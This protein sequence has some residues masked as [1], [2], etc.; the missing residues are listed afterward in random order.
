M[1]AAL[2]RYAGQRALVALCLGLAAALLPAPGPASAASVSV[3]WS[4][5][6]GGLS[7]PVQVV[8][9]KDGT[10]R[11]FIVEKAGRIRIWRD[12]SLR[13][14]PYLDIRDLVSDAG[15]RGLLSI[16][17][18][19]RWESAPYFWVSY[20]NSAGTLRVVRYRAS[21]YAANTAPRSSARPVLDVPHPAQYTNHNGG[22]LAFGNDG[23]LLI[24]TGDGGG[25][26]D[27]GNRAQSARS[28]S[29][30][31]L[32]VDVLNS[33]GS[34]RYCI[35]TTNPYAKSTVYKREIWA[36]GI[37]NA[38]RFSVDPATGYVWVADVGQGRYEEINVIRRPGRNLGWSCR[39]GS[40]VYASSRCSSGTTY[41]PPTFVYSHS[42]GSSVTGGFV[43]RGSRYASFLRGW[44]IGGDYVSGRVF[45]AR[46]TR[47]VTVGS[48]PGV[49]SFGEGE[50]REIWAVTSSGGLHRMSARV[51]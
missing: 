24:S 22:Q 15:E 49:T 48:L 11:L 30:K 45:M 5:Q 8:S 34:R 4:R 31:I 51:R 1:V 50:A 25:S 27:P 7:S 20:T 18:S 21:S 44:Y 38:W 19:P 43:Y 33:C 2:Q 35:P 46:G 47:L 26:G 29:G 12:G 41:H 39:E 40:A 28:L 17:F 14:T 16:A 23:N 9:P 36:R 10:G 3:S 6:A 13:A 32:R 42:Y 37:R